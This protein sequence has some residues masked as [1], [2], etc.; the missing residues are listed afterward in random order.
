M[1]LLSLNM[2]FLHQRVAWSNLNAELDVPNVAFALRRAELC[3]RGCMY[4]CAHILT[5]TSTPCAYLHTQS[6]LVFFGLKTSSV[7][8][9]FS[10]PH[11]R[12]ISVDSTV[13]CPP[14]TEQEE[15]ILGRLCMMLFSER[16]K[17]DTRAEVIST[18]CVGSYVDVCVWPCFL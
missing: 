8:A 5:T 10:Q 14:R 2:R 6:C 16:P 4:D 7:W 9:A 13:P 1:D 3:L 12:T 15:E 17:W 11:V 18:I